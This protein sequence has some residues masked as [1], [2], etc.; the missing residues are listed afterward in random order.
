[1]TLPISHAQ[2]AY[3]CNDLNNHELYSVDKDGKCYFENDYIG[4]GYWKIKEDEMFIVFQP[5]KPVDYIKVNFTV[6]M[7]GVAEC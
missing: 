5:V 7:E 4:K 3:I 6:T 1:M 2:L